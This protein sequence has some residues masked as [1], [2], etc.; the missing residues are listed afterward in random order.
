MVLKNFATMSALSVYRSAV[1]L[2][3]N[4]LLAFFVDP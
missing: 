4:V 1:Q 2:G 3:I